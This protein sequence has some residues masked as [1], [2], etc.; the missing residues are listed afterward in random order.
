MV[1]SFRAAVAAARRHG[2]LYFA[3]LLSEDRIVNA[4]GSAR[5]LW[6]GWIYTPTVIVWVFLSQC[7]SPDHSSR[8]A[9]ARLIAWRVARGQKPCSAETGAYCTAR[10]D[11]P[12]EALHE[13]VRDTGKQIENDVPETWLWQGRKVRVADGSTVTMPDTPANQAAYPNRNLSDP[14][15][16]FLWR[17][18]W[19]S[20]RSRRAPYWRRRSASIRGSRRARTVCFGNSTRRGARA[21]WC[22]RTV[23]SA[24]GSTSRCC[25]NGVPMW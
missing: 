13:R 21:R 1:H 2:D 14:A 19:S 16:A 23:I 8:D 18:S 20:S 12:E 25:G 6:Q 4:F 22:W 11:L 7:L 3:A 10:N 9:A 17:E 15:A 24:V 5:W